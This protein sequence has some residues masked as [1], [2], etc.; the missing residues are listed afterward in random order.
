MWWRCRICC[1]SRC[2]R[3]LAAPLQFQVAN[4]IP[5]KCTVCGS[6]WRGS[7]T[8][9]AAG[10]PTVLLV[11]V[12]VRLV[13]GTSVTLRWRAMMVRLRVRDAMRGS[14]G[15]RD[16][17]RCVPAKRAGTGV[18]RW[19]LLFANCDDV[20]AETDVGKGNGAGTCAV[21]GASTDAGAGMVV[22]VDAGTDAG[23]CT[24][25]NAGIQVD[26]SAGIDA[27]ANVGTNAIG[28]TCDDAVRRRLGVAAG[29]LRGTRR[30]CLAPGIGSCFSW[31]EY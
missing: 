15:P 16:A 7:S 3:V 13:R 11:L 18:L 27:D 23:A 28:G 24:E 25:V 5:R 9:G 10:K 1:T 22:D 31:L 8:R 21:A 20:G 30:Q 29:M 14:T 19:R 2:L 4:P 26:A 12:A 6:V 17:M